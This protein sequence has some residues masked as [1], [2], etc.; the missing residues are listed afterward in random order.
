MALSSLEGRS[1]LFTGRQPSHGRLVDLDEKNGRDF[2]AVVIFERV[3]CFKIVST[4][5]GLSA[6]FVGT[7]GA[8]FVSPHARQGID[9]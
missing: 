8:Q 2:N 7:T 3:G 9:Q 1:L 5:M 6:K 4:R